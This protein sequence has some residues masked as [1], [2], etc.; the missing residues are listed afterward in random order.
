MP[1]NRLSTYFNHRFGNKIGSLTQ[2]GPK[3]SC[4]NDCFHYSLCFTGCN[5]FLDC[6]NHILEHHFSHTRVNSNPE[7]IIQ[8]KICT[9]Q[10]TDNTITFTGLSHFIK[11]RMFQQVSRKKITGLYFLLSKYSDNSLRVKPAS[12]FTEIRKPNQLGLEFF[13][14]SGSISP[15]ISFKPSSKV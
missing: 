11:S 3:T 9:F 4:E 7:S 10:I 8:Y 12:S 15:S 5:K 13:W 6:G 2:T 1:K 14:G